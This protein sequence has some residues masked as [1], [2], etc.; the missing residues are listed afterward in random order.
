[1]LTQR[2]HVSIVQYTRWVIE[3][4]YN[5]GLVRIRLLIPVLSPDYDPSNE[6]DSNDLSEINQMINN[7]Y[8]VFRDLN[9][10]RTSA[11]E[12]QQCIFQTILNEIAEFHAEN[13]ELMPALDSW[14]QRTSTRL[15][16]ENTEYPPPQRN[17][18]RENPDDSGVR[19]NSRFKTYCLNGGLA[20]AIIATLAFGPEATQAGM[21]VGMLVGMSVFISLYSIY[22]AICA[23]SSKVILPSLKGI[24]SVTRQFVSATSNLISNKRAHPEVPDYVAAPSTNPDYLAPAGAPAGVAGLGIYPSSDPF[25]NASAPPSQ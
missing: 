25:S 5:S 22:P 6:E 20:G 23:I 10:V 18:A 3:N 19:I 21:Y 1:V 15:N 8:R 14:L 16:L 13:P 11:Q 7:P 2:Q 9:A 12:V 24:D 17:E 4:M